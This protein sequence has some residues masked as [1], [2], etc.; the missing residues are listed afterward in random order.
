MNKGIYLIAILS[1][2]SNLLPIRVEETPK[3]IEEKTVSISLVGDI[4]L[5]GRVRAQIN[6]NGTEYLWEM[7]KEYFQNDDITIGNLET[8]IT[9]RGTKWEDKK[10]NFRSDPKN[11]ITMKESGI[12][13][14]TLGN[15]HTLD[16]G[17]EGL[18]DTLEYLDKSDIKRVGGGKNKKEAMEGVI[19]DKDGLKVAVLSF[20]RVV[21]DV[22]WYA[23]DKRPGIVGAYDPHIN[24]VIAKIEEI[25]KESDVV[26]LSI[27]WGIERSIEPRKEEVALAKKLIDA[28]AD[29]IMGHHPHVLQGV[30]IYKGKPIFYSL[31]NFMFGKRN[32]ITAETM[33][34][35]VNFKDKEIDNIRIIPCSMTSGR[36]VP[37]M[38][39][40]R[41][42]KIKYMNSISKEFNTIFDVDGIIKFNQ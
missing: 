37:V 36:P 23:T 22:R 24:E 2:F 6:E 3:I 38:D 9:T 1:M 5:D 40:E 35:Q 21:P 34:A 42:E 14:L 16:Y 32:D 29:V 18:L 13:V 10:Y 19:I 30:E 12:D 15:N 4:M 31:G 17:Y 26:I 8:S 27:H 7:V 33:I 11:L 28:G 20:S 41:L 25:K 39:G